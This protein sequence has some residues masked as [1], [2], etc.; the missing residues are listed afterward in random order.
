MSGYLSYNLIVLFQ[1]VRK[2]IIVT[3]IILKKLIIHLR[4]NNHSVNS[5]CNKF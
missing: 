5:N 2:K 4:N 3:T 1:I